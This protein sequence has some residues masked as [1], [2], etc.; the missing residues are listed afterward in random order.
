MQ[1]VVQAVAVEQFLDAGAYAGLGLLGGETQVEPDLH[2]AGD[3]VVGAGAGMDI[4][5]LQTGG[6]EILVALVPFQRAQLG[7][8]RRQAMHGVVGQVRVGYMTLLAEH[9]QLAAEGPAPAVLDDIAEH[10]VAGGF[11]HQAPVNLF[12][13]RLQ[14]F[15]HLDGTVHGGAF[16]VAGDEE[17]DGALVA[18]MS[19]HETL[20]G[21]HHGGQAAL[22]VGGA[23]TVEHAVA[24][25]G[26]EGIG[27]PAFPWTRGHHV[28]VAG[29]GQQGRLFATPC[30]EVIDF[31]EAQPL[32]LK[33]D[34][35]QA[36]DHGLLAAG[37][38]RGDGGAGDQVLGEG[39][40]VGHGA[41][42]PDCR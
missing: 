12:I 5:D 42:I 8:G 10:L 31:T 6:R 35:L 26:H 14:P 4:G 20:A 1:F 11:A 19:G 3:D 41:M 28:G 30:P 32:D 40:G 24:F 21:G 16:L 13:A 33:A 25:R 27:L 29:E 37:I 34:G 22:H 7:Q 18:G 9:A 39:E 38:L 17:G 2:L 36:P 23:T 15:H